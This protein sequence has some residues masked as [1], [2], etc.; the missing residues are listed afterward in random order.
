MGDGAM[1]DFALQLRRQGPQRL[2]EDGRFEAEKGQKP[3]GCGGW[4]VG[5]E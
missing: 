4:V 2:G 3:V 5:S 1:D